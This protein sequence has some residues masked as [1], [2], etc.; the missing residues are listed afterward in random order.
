MFVK[1]KEVILVNLDDFLDVMETKKIL[2]Q[3]VF[4]CEFPVI[5]RIFPGPVLFYSKRV[6]A[7]FGLINSFL[8]V[9]I[10]EVERSV[11]KEKIK[12]RPEQFEIED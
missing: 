6:A 4:S 9:C 8:E 5:T 11:Y 1:R 3:K 10:E 7:N 2:Q 12:W